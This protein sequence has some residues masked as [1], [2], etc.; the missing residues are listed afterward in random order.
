MDCL[1][2]MKH[3]R[4]FRNLSS[5]KLRK[6]LKGTKVSALHVDQNNNIWV[7]TYDGLLGK[8][9][10]DYKLLKTYHPSS[11]G[12]DEMQQIVLLREINK[13][14]LL[15]LT[16]F[17][18]RILL[19]FDIEKETTQLFELYSRGSNITY[20]LL[21]SLRENQQ[22]ELLALISDKGLFHVNWKEN[23]LENKLS[24]M[25]KRIGCYITDFY[26]DKK[27]FY[28]F[29]SSANGLI[30]VSNDGKSL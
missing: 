27:G 19:N 6:D 13:S 1:H 23:V 25:N 29:A 14:N 2:G 11:S 20:C 4:Q 17:H 7:G 9:T 5:D 28:W 24:E 10:S 12:P 26:H 18:S 22:G 16:Q 8:Y 30:C 3:T 15:I 21:N